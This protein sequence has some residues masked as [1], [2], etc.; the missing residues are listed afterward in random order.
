MSE[1]PREF[2]GE[3]PELAE[4]R[5][6]LDEAEGV[7][8]RRIVLAPDDGRAVVGGSVASPEEADR[9]LGI[10]EGFGVPVVDRLQVDPGLREGT[11]RPSPAERV[12]PADQDEVLVGEPDMLAGPDAAITDDVAR[13]L[14]DN[15]PLQPPDEPLF[16]PTP[17]EA[18]RARTPG[19][20]EPTVDADEAVDDERPAAADLTGQD[21]REAAAGRPL[22]ALDPELDATQDDSGAEPAGVDELGVAPSEAE[23]EDRFPPPVPGTGPGAG[24]VGEPTTEGGPVG[25]EPATET[26]A[27]GADTA[28]ADPARGGSGGVQET[29]KP[30]PEA[31]EDPAIRDQP[32]ADR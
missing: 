2:G 23:A 1:E 15:E 30:G 21:L 11:E 20:E 31:E 22:P 3:P 18:R 28:S 19:P 29:G 12:E 6:A 4:I 8:A 13:S 5:A 27:I 14:D 17:A 7:D 25:G 9:A 16:P 10:V 32:P 26:G 24:A